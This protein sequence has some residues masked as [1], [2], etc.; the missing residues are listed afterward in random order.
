MRSTWM[1]S[2]VFGMSFDRK[3]GGIGRKN[4]N[5]P[6]VSKSLVY[7]PSKVGNK[8]KNSCMSQLPVR[9]ISR[10]FR[11]NFEHDFD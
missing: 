9:S 4:L 1:S 10:V 8:C 5:P 2:D 6:E 7:V 11:S 3:E